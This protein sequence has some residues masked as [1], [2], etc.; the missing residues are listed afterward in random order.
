L[1][2]TIYAGALEERLAM[3][4]FC[5]ICRERIV[6]RDAI[7]AHVAG[8]KLVEGGVLVFWATANGL[9]LKPCRDPVI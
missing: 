6:G 8:H 4:L 5:T 9:L 7:E 3:R 2:L 1:I